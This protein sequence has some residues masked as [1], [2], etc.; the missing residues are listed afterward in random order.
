MAAQDNLNPE[1]FYHGSNSRLARGD[2]VDP[3]RSGVKAIHHGS[4]TFFS[5]NKDEAGIF[6]RHVYKVRP[7]GN[8]EP[9]PYMHEGTAYRSPSHLRVTGKA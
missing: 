5:S 1:Q 7:T 2:M 4:Y 6:G 8:Y 9:D 3:D